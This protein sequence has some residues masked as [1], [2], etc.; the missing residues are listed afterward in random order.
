MGLSRYYREVVL[1]TMN[2]ARVIIDEMEVN[3]SREYWP[4]P[5]YADL[6]FSVN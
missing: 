3:T 5:T 2:S 1:E 6:L 4:Y